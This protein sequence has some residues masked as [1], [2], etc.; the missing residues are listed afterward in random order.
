[1]HHPISVSYVHVIHT[2]TE[3]SSPSLLTAMLHQVFML[4]LIPLLTHPILWPFRQ[5]YSEA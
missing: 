2:Y 4:S 1:M 3:Y 5:R